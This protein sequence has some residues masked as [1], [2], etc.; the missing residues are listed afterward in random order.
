MG[1]DSAKLQETQVSWTK[2]FPRASQNLESCEINDR[3][4]LKIE[5][6][7]VLCYVTRFDDSEI[8]LVIFGGHIW[9]S[10]NRVTITSNF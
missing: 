4:K 9:F 3:K 2:S 6:N 1:A 8:F 5:R 7:G 10:Y